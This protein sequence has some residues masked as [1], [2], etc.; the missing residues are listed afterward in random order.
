MLQ[1]T[2]FNTS[3]ASKQYDTSTPL[4]SNQSRNQNVQQHSADDILSQIE[5]F[6]RDEKPTLIALASLKRKIDLYEEEQSCCFCCWGCSNSIIDDAKEFYKKNYQVLTFEEQTNVDQLVYSYQS[7]T[8][9]GNLTYNGELYSGYVVNGTPE[10]QKQDQR[11]SISSTKSSKKPKESPKSILIMTPGKGQGT[12]EV[13]LHQTVER[14]TKKMRN[15]CNR[16][17]TTPTE[18]KQMEDLLIQVM[19]IAK[20]SIDLLK[21]GTVDE[22]NMQLI[23]SGEKLRVNLGFFKKVLAELPKSSYPDYVGQPMLSRMQTLKGTGWSESDVEEH[24]IDGRLEE[25]EK[26]KLPFPIGQ[27]KG[28]SKSAVSE[29]DVDEYSIDSRLEEQEKEK[30]TFPTSQMKVQSKSE[31]VDVDL[32][33]DVLEFRAEEKQPMN[34]SQMQMERIKRAKSHIE[35]FRYKNEQTYARL[36]NLYAFK[37]SLEVLKMVQEEFEAFEEQYDQVVSEI[38]TLITNAEPLHKTEIEKLIAK[39]PIDELCILQTIYKNLQIINPSEKQK[40]YVEEAQGWQ[41]VFQTYKGMIEEILKE[42][43]NP[44]EKSIV[45]LT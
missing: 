25:Q 16:A 3:D 41:K 38:N 30:L 22:V 14:S 23:L 21:N 40:A 29:S 34:D 28:Q 45:F 10:K 31:F 43:I 42:R 26:E 15:F 18:K 12:I 4:I 44:V 17:A 6:P 8:W 5:H 35:F 19:G 13:D 2:Y 24:S 39:F 27:I 32:E 11:D 33:D 37:D 36:V 7:R 20:G 9:V 1:T